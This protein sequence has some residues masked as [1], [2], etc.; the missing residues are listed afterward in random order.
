M[1]GGADS[2][3]GEFRV[4][5]ARLV[6]GVGDPPEFARQWASHLAFVPHTLEQAGVGG[7]QR[8]LGELK[9]VRFVATFVLPARW[10]FPAG[11][12]VNEAN[13]AE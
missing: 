4:L 2:G 11:M 12:T 8:P 1:V 10:K 6:A 7:G 9:W 3:S 5:D 13:C